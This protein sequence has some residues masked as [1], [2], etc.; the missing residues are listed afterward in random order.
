VRLWHE[1]RNDN[2]ENAVE[3]LIKDRNALTGLPRLHSGILKTS[4][5]NQ[6]HRKLIWTM[7]HR[8]MRAKGCLSNKTALAMI[9]KLAETAG[10][11]SPR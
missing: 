1:T 7:W 10:L 8:T 9:F 3:W 6:R 11:A 4:A 5:P 2:Y